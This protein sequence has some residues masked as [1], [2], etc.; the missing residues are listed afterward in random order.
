MLL[1]RTRGEKIFNVFN[2]IFFC[3]FTIAMLVPVL[4][5]LKISFETG[6]FGEL[7]ISLIPQEPSTMFYKMVLQ[8]KSIWRPF[9]NSVFITVVGT[10][11]SLFVNAMGAYTLSK[12]D[13]KGVNFF[14]YYLV[15]IPM[16][17]SGGLIPSYLLIRE[18]GLMDSL[19]ALIIPA[20]ASGWNMILIRNYYWSIPSSLIESARIDGAEEFTVFTKVILPLATPV[21]AAIGLF[22]G[23]GFWN[24]FFSAVIYINDPSKYTFTVKLREMIAVQ[25]DLQ[26]QFEKMAMDSGEDLLL[27]NLTQEGLSSAIMIISLIPIIIVYPF[28]QK[29]FVTGLMVG[30]IKG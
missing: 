4:Y 14:V 29:Y 17:F 6:G 13:L 25:Q 28:L 24:T 2:I 18:L 11:L 1:K 12:R 19:A 20:L 26:K 9:L 23:V 22:T 30:S 10:V 8:D 15:V 5:V 27:A 7:S 16:L 3:L 21:L